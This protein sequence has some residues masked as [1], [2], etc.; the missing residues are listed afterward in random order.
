M[1][2]TTQFWTIERLPSLQNY[3]KCYLGINPSPQQVTICAARQR[4]IEEGAA[5]VLSEDHHCPKARATRKI[6]LA[7]LQQVD[8]HLFGGWGGVSGRGV[9]IT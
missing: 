2:C 6:D 1:N 8:C 5:L 9:G 3:P 4:Q 7:K